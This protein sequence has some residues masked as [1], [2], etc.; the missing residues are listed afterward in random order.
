MC[1]TVRN[2]QCSPL[3]CQSNRNYRSAPKWLE[4]PGTVNIRVYTEFKGNSGIFKPGPFFVLHILGS[5]LLIGTTT[6][7]TGAV[8]HLLSRN[9]RQVSPPTD[10]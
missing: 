9:S 3:C 6:F 5:K 7:G 8:D 10:F 1:H 4:V 2:V